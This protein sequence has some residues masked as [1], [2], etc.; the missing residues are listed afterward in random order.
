MTT[1]KEFK[2]TDAATGKERRPIFDRRNDGTRINAMM[3]S[4]VGNSQAGQLV[5][6][7]WR[8]TVLLTK[9]LHQ[10]AAI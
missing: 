4:K 2:R 10:T 7:E 8:E 3:T 6:A 1:D 5:H 9:G